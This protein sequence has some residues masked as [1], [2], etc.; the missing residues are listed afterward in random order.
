MQKFPGKW[1]IHFSTLLDLI[2]D[3]ENST[4][5]ARQA[6]AFRFSGARHTRR[7]IFFT[8]TLEPGPP[9]T[10][11][12]HRPEEG[13]NL[14]QMCMKLTTHVY[15]TYYVCVRNLLQKPVRDSSGP[16]T[17]RPKTRHFRPGKVLL[18]FPCG[19]CQTIPALRAC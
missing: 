8:V 19:R 14:L 11:P 9:R 13:M 18:P 4:S 17:I 6:R 15:K 2:I 3:R 12:P 1:P 16:S 5:N 7:L 10:P